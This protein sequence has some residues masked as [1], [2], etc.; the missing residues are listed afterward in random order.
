MSTIPARAIVNVTPNV[1]SAG[2]S[3]LD[4]VG[5]LLSTSNRVPIGTIQ[6]FASA[7]D[8]ETFFGANSNEATM[9]GIYF[10]GF[11]SSNTKPGSV[12]FAQ[13]NTA[14]VAAYLRGGSLASMTLA[15]LQ[16]V[17][18]ALAVTIDGSPNSGNL[19]LSA[20]TSFSNAALLIAASLDIEGA[21]AAAFTADIAGTVMTVSAVGSGTLAVGQT[22]EGAGVTSGT[23]ITSL[24]TGTGGTGT[25]NVNHTQTVASEAMTSDLQAVTFDSVSSAFVINSATTGTS[26]TIAFATG[27]AATTL[28]LTSAT[29]AVLSQGANAA[30]PVAFMNAAAQKTQNWATFALLFDPDNSGITNKALFA[31]WANDQNDRYAF[32]CWDADASPTVTVP[33]TASLGY[34]ITQNEY[35]GTAL[36]Y[37]PNGPELAVFE[38]GI[39]ASIDFTETNGRTTFK[40]RKQSGLSASVTNETVANNLE[41]NGYNYYAAYATAKEEFTFFANGNI[42]GPFVWA[43]SFLNQIW[44]N[45]SFQVS[46]MTLLTN[47]KSIPYNFAGSSLIESG[48]ADT[49]N[50]GLNFGAIRVGVPLSAQQAAQVNSA[51]G[52]RISDALFNNGWYLQVLPASAEVRAARGSPPAKFWYMDGQSVQAIDLASVNI[53]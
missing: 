37:S 39:A 30:A 2:G 9:A 48:C 7:D 16:A 52:V 25:Y 5:L 21:Q 12:L 38:C 14:N 33:A 44:L 15:E 53:Q 34:Y 8:V 47:V 22:V 32:M 50:A 46:L 29:G 31:S 51:A 6:S 4:L 13:Y 41:A 3:G 26:S 24:G 27:A 17:N 43:D 23:Y 20:A 42:S 10:N 40:F 45:N 19:D 49:I 36:V 35:S 18:T 11:D 1:L 28:K